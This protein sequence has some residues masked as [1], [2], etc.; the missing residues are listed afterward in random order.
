M[1]PLKL[2]KNSSKNRISGRINRLKRHGNM[3]PGV[4]SVKLTASSQAA[5]AV[6]WLSAKVGDQ[7]HHRRRSHG[8]RRQHSPAGVGPNS[9]S[10]EKPTSHLGKPASGG[11]GGTGMKFS[12][13][14]DSAKKDS[15]TRRRRDERFLLSIS[16]RQGI[17]HRLG[18][19]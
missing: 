10:S 18:N 4:L 11:P 13:P 6:A 8:T 12:L 14:I 7:F 19:S 17:G 5:H 1:L 9:V 15:R 3:W 2:K 16:A